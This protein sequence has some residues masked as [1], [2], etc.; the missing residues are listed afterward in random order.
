MATIHGQLKHDTQDKLEIVVNYQ[1][2]LPW[3]WLGI[4]LDTLRNYVILHKKTMI[5]A[6]QFFI[7]RQ[8]L[9][10]NHCWTPQIK[11]VPKYIHLFKKELK[12]KYEVTKAIVG[13][14]LIG[15]ALLKYVFANFPLTVPVGQTL[16]QWMM[17][18]SSQI[19]QRMILPKDVQD[20]IGDN[21]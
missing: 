7:S 14:F 5:V 17:W 6:L 20:Y 1:A 21:D 18:W 16:T 12:T 4:L 8:Q 19:I 10:W 13:K 11:M 3:Q 9:W 2:S 15:I